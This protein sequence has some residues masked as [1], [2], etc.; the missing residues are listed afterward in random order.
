MKSDPPLA[1]SSSPV[2]CD[3]WAGRPGTSA[4][5]PARLGRVGRLGLQ[6]CDGEGA[7]AL[8]IRFGNF[9]FR[10]PH[11]ITVRRGAACHLSG[12]EPVRLARHGRERSSFVQE[13]QWKADVTF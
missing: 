8:W 10:L 9:L 4:A 13:L 7:R 1:K 12:W 5:V 11:E 6:D 2:R 3:V